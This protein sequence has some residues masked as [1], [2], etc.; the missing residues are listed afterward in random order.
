MR[1]NSMSLGRSGGVI[2]KIQLSM[3]YFLKCYLFVS[4]VYNRR[5]KTSV[6]QAR[7]ESAV[8]CLGLVSGEC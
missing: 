6:F 5:G 2:G 8:P 4:L 7:D 3:I 1:R